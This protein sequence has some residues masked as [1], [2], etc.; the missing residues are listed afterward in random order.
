MALPPNPLRAFLHLARFY[1]EGGVVVDDRPYLWTLIQPDG[2]VIARVASDYYAL[3]QA[4]QEAVL[5]V[6]LARIR[7][8]EGAAGTLRRLLHALPGYGWLPAS[9]TLV[10]GGTMVSLEWLL[11]LLVAS[12]GIGYG[13][14][15]V[16]PLA[17]RGGLRVIRWRL[18]RIMR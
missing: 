2:D 6:H 12:G 4:T 10:G 16:R 13:F 1:G 5:S 17:V 9:V 8:I 18:R 7:T 3:D 15:F 11:G 14:R